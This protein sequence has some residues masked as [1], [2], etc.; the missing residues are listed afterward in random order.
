[1]GLR[2]GWQGVAHVRDNELASVR[3]HPDRIDELA[4]PRAS[5]SEGDCLG[6]SR[7]AARPARNDVSRNVGSVHAAIESGRAQRCDSRTISRL[8]RNPRPASQARAGACACACIV[9]ERGTVP[10][11]VDHLVPFDLPS[12][13]A[14]QRVTCTVEGASHPALTSIKRRH[15]SQPWTV[16]VWFL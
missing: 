4:W 9:R 16:L 14:Q 5:A 11:R 3:H 10:V 6:R 1:M 7:T 13:F 12:A 8:V 15:V 2:L